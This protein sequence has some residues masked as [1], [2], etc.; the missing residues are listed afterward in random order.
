MLLNFRII[1]L[2]EGMENDTSYRHAAGSPEEAAKL[3][4]GENLVQS[5]KRIDLRAIVYFQEGGQ[6]VSIVRLYRNAEE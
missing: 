4:F 1:K 3:A 2:G 5:G 6:P